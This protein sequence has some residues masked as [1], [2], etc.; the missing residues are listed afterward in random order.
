MKS[1]RR[2]PAVIWTL[3]SYAPGKEPANFDK[4]FLREWFVAQ[5]YRGEGNA[6]VIAARSHRRRWPN[7]TFRLMSG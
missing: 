5:G 1:I 3:D 7:A 2:I 4:E 6:P